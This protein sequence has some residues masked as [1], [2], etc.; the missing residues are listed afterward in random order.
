M[1]QTDKTIPTKIKLLALFLTVNALASFVIGVDF[2]MY[3]PESSPLWL[4]G[5]AA[6]IVGVLLGMSAYGVINLEKWG[7]MLSL[8]CLTLMFCAGML[9][10]ALLASVISVIA[11]YYLLKKDT[12][13]LF[14]ASAS[15]R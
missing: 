2:V 4:F 13:S 10:K 14:F 7:Y 12:R 6:I 9:G 15:T 11:M 3:N 1:N 8:A 5:G